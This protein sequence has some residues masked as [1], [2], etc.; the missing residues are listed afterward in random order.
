MCIWFE[1]TTDLSGGGWHSRRESAEIVLRLSSFRWLPVSAI[2]PGREK[3]YQHLHTPTRTCF[4]ID[5]AAVKPA[6]TSVLEN[7]LKRMEF[8]RQRTHSETV[9]ERW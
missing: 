9:Q 5:I 2:Y 8:R 7:M 4:M 1:D 3:T 6:A